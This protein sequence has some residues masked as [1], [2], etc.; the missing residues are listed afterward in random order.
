MELF[1]I[2]WRTLQWQRPLCRFTCNL[3]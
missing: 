1:D 3:R 2:C